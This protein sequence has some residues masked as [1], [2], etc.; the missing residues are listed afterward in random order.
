[1]GG[2][3]NH[4]LDLADG[5]LVKDN[6]IA[7]LQ[8]RGL[9]IGDAVSLAR[10]ARPG[11][12]VEVEVTTLEQ[13]REALAAGADELLLDNMSPGEMRNVVMIVKAHD[14]RPA[15]EASG[16]I[17]LANARAV[18]ETGVDYISMGAVTHSAK[19]LDM[20]LEVEVG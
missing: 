5:I 20:S 6:H 12:R 7:A 9:S 3:T 16:G 2:G 15:I 1:M 4:R 18:A 14:P 13:A 19:A 10:E 17:T 11:M 8:A